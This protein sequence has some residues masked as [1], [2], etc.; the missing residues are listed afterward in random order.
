MCVLVCAIK[1]L[2][3]ENDEIHLKLLLSNIWQLMGKKK[4]PAQPKSSM[5][6]IYSSDWDV[7]KDP[8]RE[9]TCCSQH[10]SGDDSVSPAANRVSSS[11]G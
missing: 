1:R 6:Y 5:S 2:K 10:I 7:P 4:K 8:S 11:P 3:W 9:E